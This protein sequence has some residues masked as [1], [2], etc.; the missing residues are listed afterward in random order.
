MA[1][2]YAKQGIR[3]NVICPAVIATSQSRRVQ[4][5]P[6][7]RARLKD[8][9]PLTGDLGEPKDVAQAAL[10]LASDASRFVT[11]VVLPVDGGWTAR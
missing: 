5:D 2:T 1:V 7:L 6:R 4:E 8:V 9:Q 3:A 10:Y 11:G